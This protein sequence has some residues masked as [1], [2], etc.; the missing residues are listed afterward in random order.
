MT[1]PSEF[2]YNLCMILGTIKKI[3]TLTRNI[4]IICAVY[5]TIISLFSYLTSDH[6]TLNTKD[7]YDEYR[8]GIYSNI[9]NPQLNSTQKGRI[10]VWIYRAALCNF[11]GEGCTTDP[12]D[13]T[14]RFSRSLFG[15]MTTAMTIPYQAPPA[16]F[17]FWFRDGL[18]NA[19]FVPK[20]YA[21]EGI[22][23]SSIKGYRS[24][25]S[26]FRNLSYLILVLIIV[27]VGIMIMF[28]KQISPQTV[29]TIENALPRIVTT[30]IFITFS[31]AIA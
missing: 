4:L 15:M 12:N 18:E 20:S 28:R 13:T 14:D 23:F 25:W 10:V 26:I 16:S 2:D 17:A 29:V 6:N 31:F 8:R 9:N 21:A 7:T 30:L 24:I 1:L 11:I 22:G 27:T 5:A 3:T 19:G